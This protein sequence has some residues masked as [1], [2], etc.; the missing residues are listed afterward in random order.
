MA[1]I[2]T[3]YDIFD[4][5][6]TR[7]T[8]TPQGIFAIMQNHLCCDVTYSDIPNDVRENFFELR[9]SAEK[10]ARYA[11]CKDGKEEITHKEIYDAL[12]TTRELTEEMINKLLDLEVMIELENVI[13]IDKTIEDILSLISNG[14]RIVFISD[15]YLEEKAIRKLLVKVNPSLKNVPIYVSSLYNKTK[16]SGNLY[17]IVQEKESVNYNMWHHIGDNIDSDIEIPKRLGIEANRPYYTE[18]M[19]IEKG[20]L[21]SEEDN[22]DIQLLL[23]I[24]K[25]TRLLYENDNSA[26][27]GSSLGGILLGGYVRWIL[28]DALK[29][30]LKTLYFVARDG[31]VLKQLADVFISNLKLPIKTKYIYGSRKAWRMPSQVIDGLD[32]MDIFKVSTPDFL[33][34]FEKVADIF[35]ISNMELLKILGLDESY[36]N[37]N[38]SRIDLDVVFNSLNDNPNFKAYVNE[39]QVKRLE[40]VVSYLKQEI[41][42]TDDEIAFV[43]IGGTGYTQKCI[44]KI[45]GT[46]C[47]KNIATYYFSLYS[48]N[49]FESKMF[50]NFIPDGL[51]IK[52]AIEP[53][54]RALHG[55]TIGYEN[56][57]GKTIPILDNAENIEDFRNCGYENYL[58]GLRQ[59]ASTFVRYYRELFD[60]TINRKAIR[61]CWN[62]YTHVNDKVL[63]DFIGEVPFDV[64][65]AG[66][67]VYAPKLTI[68]DIKKIYEDNPI[69]TSSWHYNGA[70]LNMS[71]LR[72]DDEEK[73]ILKQIKNQNVKR[74]KSTTTEEVHSVFARI[75]KSMFKNGAKLALYGAGALGKSLRNQIVFENEYELIAWFDRNYLL[76]QKDGYNVIDPEKIDKHLF[77][78]ILIAVFDKKIAEAIKKDILSK[79]IN[80]DK[81]VWISPKMF[82]DGNGKVN[83]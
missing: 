45:L 47:K 5:V 50:R 20:I 10:L 14:K 1:N 67:G 36:K 30:K 77:D 35:E 16:A 72:L 60:R 51:Y 76:L 2:L 9:V 49:K 39:K 22:A 59:Y 46:F 19:D 53:L 66:H 73:E 57:D 34:D 52:D 24:S 58:A 27:V 69:G 3:S 25:N 28:N 13:G 71:C 4:T 63:L 74:M 75:P 7:R 38:L 42:I 18:L 70:S 79:G 65:G 37:Y 17:K 82:L 43:E 54:C 26:K 11:Y 6:I 31:F 48:L 78:F 55:Q 56:K 21:K 62:Y 41:D 32:V 80:V 8:A 15:M 44:A 81:I 29:R 68:S 23:G 61:K 64:V 40:L 33:T 83:I 12:N